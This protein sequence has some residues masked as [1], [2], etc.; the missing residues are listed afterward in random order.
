LKPALGAVGAPSVSDASVPVLWPRER[1]VLGLL[2]RRL[3]NAEIAAELDISPYTAKSH[4]DRVFAKLGVHSRAEAVAFAY[5]CGL[6][7]SPQSERLEHAYALLARSRVLLAGLPRCGVHG[8]G[9]P[10]RCRV[11][12]AWV[13]S[14]RLL[15]EIDGLPGVARG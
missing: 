9:D 4:V 1:E 14:R 15:A 7:V 12:R 5:E 11:C 13:E 8:G 10:L 6:L 3:T 2:A